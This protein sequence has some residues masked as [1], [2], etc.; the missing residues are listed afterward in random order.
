MDKWL[1]EFPSTLEAQVVIWADKIAYITHDLEDFLRSSI[2][3]NLQKNDDKI[4]NKIYLILNK[5]VK[6]LKKMK[7][8]ELRDLIRNIINNL[9]ETSA[10]NI[11]KISDFTQEKVKE[12]T[13][14]RSEKDKNKNE[15]KRR[16]YL[17]SLIINLSDEYR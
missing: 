13:K 9:I 1:K 12:E 7:D 4:E 6:D 2:Y 10:E 16:M 14:N 17:N 8:F 11:L 3:I 15:N 5:I